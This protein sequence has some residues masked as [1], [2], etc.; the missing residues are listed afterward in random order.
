MDK[1]NYNEIEA[2][3][4]ER[5]KRRADKNNKKMKVSG[6]SVF[7]LAKIISKKGK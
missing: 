1:Q 3:M 6:K 4:S 5:K 7:K 2:E